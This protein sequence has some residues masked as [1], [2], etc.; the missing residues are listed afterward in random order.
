MKIALGGFAMG[1]ASLSLAAKIG[2]AEKASYNLLLAS[3][4]ILAFLTYP[5]FN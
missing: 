2:G 4:L 1:F 3:V 5:A